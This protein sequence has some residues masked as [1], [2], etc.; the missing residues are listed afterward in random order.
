MKRWAGLGVALVVAGAALLAFAFTPDRPDPVA[1]A[2]AAIKASGVQP[3]AVLADDVSRNAGVRGE[4]LE[5]G[6][7]LAFAFPEPYA[8]TWSMERVDYP[9]ILVPLSEDGV[10][11]ARV[12]MRPCGSSSGARCHYRSP[13][14][15]I[16]FLEVRAPS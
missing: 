16:A 4:P 10:P 7:V 5:V 9:L 13:V 14:P 15:A 2:R 8:G 1:G 6:Q 3:V 12:R 11:L